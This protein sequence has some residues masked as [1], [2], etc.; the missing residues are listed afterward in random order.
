MAGV[1]SCFAVETD[2][3]FCQEADIVSAFATIRHQEHVNRNKELLAKCMPDALFAV[4]FSLAASHAAFAPALGGCDYVSFLVSGMEMCQAY[5]IAPVQLVIKWEAHMDR[6]GLDEP[7]KSEHF[8][9]IRADIARKTNVKTEKSVQN[10]AKRPSSTATTAG[11]FRTICSIESWSLFANDSSIQQLHTVLITTAANITGTAFFDINSIDKL[12]ESVSGNPKRMGAAKV[13]VEAPAV[14]GTPQSFSTPLKRKGMDTPSSVLQSTVRPKMLPQTP[15]TSD[16][17][18]PG[19]VSVCCLTTLLML[20]ASLWALTFSFGQSEETPDSAR[21]TNRE[22]KF[23]TLSTL[24]EALP[25]YA[26]NA[27]TASA[28]CEIKVIHDVEP[29]R[30][31]YEKVEA[32]CF[33]LRDRLRN[34][35]DGIVESNRLRERAA[36]DGGEFLLSPVN[37][38]SQERIW[39]CGRICCDGDVGTLNPF[40]VCLEGANGR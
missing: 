24:N 23:K 3:S 25:A 19:P 30:F 13:K 26:R 17:S 36:E 18:S 12:K 10:A 31:M 33:S 32:K 2:F 1:L 39:C 5:S 27:E 40:S 22:H 28:R 29:F 9:S 38:A 14:P 35:T 6:L 16:A 21:Y 8:D 37:M 11:S 20:F 15:R 7:P 34:V 4:F